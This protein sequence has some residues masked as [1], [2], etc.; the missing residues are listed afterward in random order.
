MNRYPL[1]KNATVII[2]LVLGLLYALPNLFGEVP[3]VQVSSVKA[4]V[5]LDL[6]LQSRIEEVLAA[7]AVKPTGLFFEPNSIRVRLADTDTQLKAKDVIERA[8]NPD[9][10]DASYSVALNLLS[11]SP[12]WLT[13]LGAKP[14]YLGLDLRGGVHFLL[15]VDMKGALTKRLDS[16]GADLRTLLRDKNIRHGGITREGNLLSLRIRE[17]DTR[18]KARLV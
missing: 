12:D 18:D 2:T 9:P 7:A 5:K 1:W 10:A 3:A 16:T 11:A 15:E 13:K 4:T 6:R 14:M 8:L 17:A